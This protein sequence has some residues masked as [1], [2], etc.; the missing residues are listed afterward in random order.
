MKQLD[1]QIYVTPLIKGV[2]RVLNDHLQ[3]FI[4]TAI[5]MFVVIKTL[6]STRSW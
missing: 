4:Q 3:Y 2:Y 5:H 6:I 1:T